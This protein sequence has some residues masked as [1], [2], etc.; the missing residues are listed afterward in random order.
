MIKNRILEI[1][2]AFREKGIIS[3]DELDETSPKKDE[4]NS[5][6]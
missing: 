3:D 2:R 6:S 5:L 4:K 1:V